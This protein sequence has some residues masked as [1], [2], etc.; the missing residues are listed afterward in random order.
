MS[1]DPQAEIRRLRR[2]L[3]QART[4]VTAVPLGQRP[5]NAGDVL[6]VLDGALRPATRKAKANRLA[7]LRTPAESGGVPGA[8]EAPAPETG[9]GR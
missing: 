8:V 1:S 3:R 9:G 7:A 6:R 5:H 4:L 2:A